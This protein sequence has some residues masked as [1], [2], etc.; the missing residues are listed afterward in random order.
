A[1][2]GAI[3]LAAGEIIVVRDNDI[4]DNGRSHVDPVC[5]VFMLHVSGY[6][7]ERNRIV[8]NAP[9]TASKDP[10]RPGIRGGIVGRSVRP[11]TAV[12]Q[13]RCLG[14]VGRGNGVPAARVFGNIV[15]GPEG[16]PVILVGVGAM[17]VDENQLT[18]RGVA[19][20]N[21][22]AAGPSGGGGAVFDLLDVLG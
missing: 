14:P 6:V 1:A 5:G 9:R 11:P 19:T 15:V 8:D 7:V 16:R 10:P 4:E 2:A 3:A 17:A 21:V 22:G 12:I 20:A 18:S 13:T